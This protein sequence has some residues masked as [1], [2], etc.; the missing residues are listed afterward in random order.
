MFMIGIELSSRPPGVDAV[1]TRLPQRVDQSDGPPPTNSGD[2]DP[3]PEPTERRRT[4]D[5]DDGAGTRALPERPVDSP[6][7]SPR[8]PRSRPPTTP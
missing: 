1:N 8:E 6:G 7:L 2:P 5:V 3:E 4:S